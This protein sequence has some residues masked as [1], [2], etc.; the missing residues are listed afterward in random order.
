[1]NPKTIQGNGNL[2]VQIN[3]KNIIVNTLTPSI[4]NQAKYFNNEYVKNK[5]IEA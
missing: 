5:D 4:V 3:E 1:M 2:Q